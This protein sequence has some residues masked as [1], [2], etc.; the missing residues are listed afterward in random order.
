MGG[1]LVSLVALT[2]FILQFF[3]SLEEVLS[4]WLGSVNPFFLGSELAEVVERYPSLLVNILGET[5]LR[6]TAFFPDPH[7]LSLYLGAILPLAYVWQRE[8]GVVYKIS[9]GIISIA[10]LMAFSRGGYVALLITSLVGVTLLGVAPLVKYWKTFLVISSCFFVLIFSTPLGGRFIS[11]WSMDDGSRVERIR[12]LQEAAGFVMEHP[13]LGVGIGNY[14]LALS[15]DIAL[16]DPV[17]AHNLYLDIA[18]EQGLIGLILF[19]LAVTLFL[20]EGYL[21]WKLTGNAYT[22]AAFLGLVYLLA[23]GLFEVPI[24]SY[25]VL[26]VMLLL[27]HSLTN[28]RYAN[29]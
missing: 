25:H 29:S 5:Y 3:W 4:F 14:P 20:R 12:L 7:T 6:T 19:L 24:Y 23:H 28:D 8:R 11:I 27:M 18:V 13:W 15:S 21:N 17:Y 26:A 2:Q 10:F 16:D 22:I 9:F 1:V